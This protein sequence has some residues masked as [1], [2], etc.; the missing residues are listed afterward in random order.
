MKKHPPLYTP[1]SRQQ[2][3]AAHLHRGQHAEESALAY[4]QGHGLEKVAVNFR[5]RM[6]EIDIIATD[7]HRLVFIEVRYRK[8]RD[9]GG[10]AVSITRRKRAR[11]I[12]TA[13]FFL[14]KYGADCECR[15]D[16]IEMSPCQ[17]GRTTGQSKQPHYHYNW[18][19]DA[20]AAL[21]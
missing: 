11:I 7:A 21:A 1:H 19:K 4:L 5:C 2:P 13:A 20:F 8:H 16:V 12:N 9:Y 10:G 3:S 14:Q 17:H 6:G 18:I 15:F